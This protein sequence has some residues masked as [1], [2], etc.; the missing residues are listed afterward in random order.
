LKAIGHILARYTAWI[1]HILGPLGI[2]GVFVVAFADSALLGMPIDAVVAAYVYNDRA[3]FYVYVLLASLGSAVGSIP[4]YVLGFVGGEKVLR[5]RIPEER[6]LRIHSSF[7]RHEFWALMFPAMLPPPTPLKVFVLAAAVFEMRFH[8]FLAAIFAGR[9]VRFG[10]L[11]LL[12][13]RFGP[14]IV[15]LAGHMFRQHFFWLLAAILVL[16]AALLLTMRKKNRQDPRI[17][18]AAERFDD[19]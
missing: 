17:A 11:A 14:Q 13:L 4:L 5:K 15:V 16:L 9:V 2:W 12:T 6:F 19:E 8:H 1:W 7:E 18:A 3:H 10:V